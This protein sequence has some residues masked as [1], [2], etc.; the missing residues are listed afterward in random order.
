MSNNA[1]AEKI[2]KTLEGVAAL[3]SSLQE[4]E[5]NDSKEL[6]EA[7]SKLAIVV[8]KLQAKTATIQ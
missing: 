2:E 1:L 7:I 3:Q 6:Q 4:R 5:V 8:A